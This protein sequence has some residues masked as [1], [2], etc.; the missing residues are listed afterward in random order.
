MR[1]KPLTAEFIHAALA[2]RALTN[3]KLLDTAPCDPR[4]SVGSQVINDLVKRLQGERIMRTNTHNALHIKR[5]LA[6]KDYKRS[7]ECKV[8]RPDG[9]EVVL[10]TFLIVA[11]R[12]GKVK[13]L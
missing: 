1:C 11:I 7:E 5:E 4:N 13:V 12:E 3:G 10:P 9:T 8:I 2:T 6:P